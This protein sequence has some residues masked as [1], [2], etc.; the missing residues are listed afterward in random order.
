MEGVNS[1][2]CHQSR[3]RFS[4]V[5]QQNGE[6]FR[7][8]DEGQL[9]LTISDDLT[10]ISD[11]Q[12]NLRMNERKK[13][14]SSDSTLSDRL[15]HLRTVKDRR[16]NTYS[17]GKNKKKTFVM[18]ILSFSFFSLLS[19]KTVFVRAEENMKKNSGNQVDD[20]HHGDDLLREV[21]ER[22][23]FVNNNEN[24]VNFQDE[25][26]SDW[27]SNRGHEIVK[28]QKPEVD[29]VYRAMSESY[30]ANRRRPMPTEKPFDSDVEETKWKSNRKNNK[31]LIKTRRKRGTTT[32]EKEIK[33]KNSDDMQVLKE[34]GLEID[35]VKGKAKA[36]GRI[37]Y[38][39]N[40][41]RL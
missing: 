20:F 36:Y 13:S 23:K 30:E 35:T 1:E 21:K 24:N 32:R 33:D 38:K 18:I 34:L 40:R 16:K 4:R 6:K 15:N 26:N 27:F 28:F 11:R 8:R 3:C 41:T 25:N 22:P 31:T 2:G 29:V 10:P 12:L 5:A 19:S 7:N 14:E 17:S 39:I 37:F 9:N